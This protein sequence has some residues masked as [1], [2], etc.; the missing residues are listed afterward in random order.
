MVPTAVAMNAIQA[1]SQLRYRPIGRDRPRIIADRCDRGRPNRAATPRNPQYSLK[2]RWI[3][4]RFWL[5]VNASINR[6]RAFTG[7]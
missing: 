1:R 6:I 7:M 3:S 5:R 2:M 4:S